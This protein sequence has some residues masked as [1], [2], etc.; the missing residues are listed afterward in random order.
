MGILAKMRNDFS[1]FVIINSSWQVFKNVVKLDLC[2]HKNMRKQGEQDEK[3]NTKLHIGAVHGVFTAADVCI[4][5]DDGQ[6]H[7]RR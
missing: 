2:E 1:L 4:R 6:R 7:L 5:G 3:E